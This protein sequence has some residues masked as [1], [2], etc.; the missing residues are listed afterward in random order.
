MPELP[1]VETIRR[2]LVPQLEGRCIQHA[3]SHPS[4]KFTSATQAVGTSIQT[5]TRKG[6]YL[7]FA[8]SNSNELVIHLGMSGSLFVA[9][10]IQ[11]H[12]PYIR[13]Q[14]HLQD[15]TWLIFRDIRRFGRIRYVPSGCYE[16]ISTLKSMGPDALS[17]EF[18]P[19]SLYLAL[20]KSSRRIP[21]QLLSQKPV[22]GVG[23]IYS[24]EALWMS[25]IHPS[26]RQIGR[27]KANKL[28]AALLQV[29]NAALANG[30]TTLRDYRNAAGA[31]GK[32]QHALACYGRSGQPCLKCDTPLKHRTYDARTLTF[33]PKCQGN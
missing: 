17:P 6:K 33:C 9:P 27:A 31:K 19:E 13:A 15:N 12:D 32:H 26:K 11:K 25:G 28:H 8:L 1:E 29:L 4:D 23:N 20:R 16:T 22:A 3:C 21:T 30:G 18:T 10:E 2:Q 7:I 5:I 24:T 14:W